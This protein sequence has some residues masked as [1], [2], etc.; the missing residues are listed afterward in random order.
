V[1]AL[2]PALALALTSATASAPSVWIAQISVAG[3]SA[4]ET[5]A[6]PERV[7]K[8]LQAVHAEVVDAPLADDTCAADPKCVGAAAAKI[9]AGTALTMRLV[10]GGPVLQVSTVVLD[11]TGSEWFREEHIVQMGDFQATSVLPAGLAARFARAA[12]IAALTPD[13]PVTTEE[14]GVAGP[15]PVDG[16]DNEEV[17]L[18]GVVGLGVA[19]LGLVGGVV[20]V[21]VAVAGNDVIN[22][23]GIAGSEKEAAYVWGPAGIA[24]A[25]IGGAIALGG[26]VT[27]AIG[28]ATQE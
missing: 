28:L 18:L 17:P 2:L 25:V 26:A 23:P 22:D 9:G 24:I 16:G 13:A 8:E 4:E 5:A 15:A 14:P 11:T 7:L 6:L 20:G 3:L 21:A 10:R 27:A 1:T 19:A 12:P